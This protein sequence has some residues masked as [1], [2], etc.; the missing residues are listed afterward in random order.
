M[1]CSAHSIAEYYEA[2]TETILRRYGPGPRIHYHTGFVEPDRLEAPS[3]RK[4]RQELMESQVRAL[5]YAAEIWRVASIQFT[6][7]LDIGCGLGGGSIFWAEHFGAHVT[8]VSNVPTHLQLVQRFAAQTGTASR[9]QPLLCDALRVPGNECFDAAVAVDS[10]SSLARRPWFHRLRQVLRPGGRVLIYDCFLGKR[11]YE[12]AF[13]H[14]WY[15][16]IGTFREYLEAAGE[17]RF[18]LE[19]FDDVS[20]R[21][22]DFWT[23]TIS[24]AAAEMREQLLSASERAGLE[25][26]IQVHRLMRQGLDDGGLRYAL[27]IF[28]KD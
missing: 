6:D 5:Y 18:R 22:R 24:L 14:H 4:L 16:Q 26:S 23:L 21:T 17:A 8:A 15:A 3:A 19:L 27:A 20:H 9:V 7:I 13:N 2:K 11:E 28:V 10:S 25:E 1:R 12:G